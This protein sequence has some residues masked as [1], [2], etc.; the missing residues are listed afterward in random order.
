MSGTKIRFKSVSPELTPKY[1]KNL[2]ISY[3]EYIRDIKIP[4]LIV[5]S[6]FIFDFLCVHPFLDGNGRVSRLLTHLLLIQN[7]FK[8]LN[9]VSLDKII[10][11]HSESYYRALHE[12]SQGW[13]EQKHDMSYW[14][15]FFLSIIREAYTELFKKIENSDI[16][17]SKTEIVKSVIS[18]KKTEFTLAEIQRELPSVSNVM[19]RKV[20][21][22]LKKDY[23]VVSYG[24]GRGARWKVIL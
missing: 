13:H 24:K 5:I 9:Y 20:L 4:Q 21:T 17:S 7:D 3:E 22:Q 18:T 6:S 23:K 14:H 12:S 2:C 11:R 10:K 15:I 8:A 16:R 1:I 19:I